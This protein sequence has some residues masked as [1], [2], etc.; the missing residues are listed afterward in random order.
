MTPR[1]KKPRGDGVSMTEA[2]VSGAVKSIITMSGGQWWSTEVGFVGHWVEG[3]DGK[4]KARPRRGGTRTT[5]GWPDIS[6]LM[7]RPHNYTLTIEAKGTKTAVRE[8]QWR[9]ALYAMRNGQP[10]LMVRSAEALVWGLWWLGLLPSA[11]WVNRPPLPRWREDRP[12]N[13]NYLARTRYLYWRQARASPLYPLPSVDHLAG[14]GHLP[15]P[16]HPEPLRAQD[17]YIVGPDAAFAD[18][19]PGLG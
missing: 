9:Y 7:R 4:W 18:D 1:D 16:P 11:S 13:I 10:H 14:W 12:D 15:Q 6:A 5:P 2:I 17:D 19:A 8:E 3:E